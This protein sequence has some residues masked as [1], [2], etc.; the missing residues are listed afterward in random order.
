MFNGWSDKPHIKIVDGIHPSELVLHVHRNKAALEEFERIYGNIL[1]YRA[2]WI[3]TTNIIARLRDD[4]IGQNVI[5]KKQEDILK[6]SLD[7][8]HSVILNNLLMTS[9]VNDDLVRHLTSLIFWEQEFGY[10][11]SNV[12]YED[13]LGCY[14]VNDDDN[15]EILKR[16]LDRY[17]EQILKFEFNLE[18]NIDP[19]LK[20]YVNKV[21][22]TYGTF[23]AFR[24]ERK[25]ARYMVDLRLIGAIPDKKSKGGKT[26]NKEKD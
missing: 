10:G 4:V 26:A 9:K 19:K 15:S 6:V 24:D 18:N 16:A 14:V 8:L 22:T 23:K 12:T 11:M 21:Q 13:D 5:S 25:S 20:E 1:T 2:I 7:Q 17:G 3:K